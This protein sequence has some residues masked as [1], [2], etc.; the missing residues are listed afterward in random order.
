MSADSYIIRLAEPDDVRHLPSVER[1]AGELFRT[2]M[3]ETGL[4]P[5]KLDDVSDF[6]ELEDARRRNHLW[7]ATTADGLPIAWAMALILDGLA[8][9]DEIDVLPEHGRQGVGTRLLETV[10]QWAR[11]A[12][13][14]KIT[15]STFRD[16]PWNR[17]FYEQ[18]GFRVVDH[19]ALLPEHRALVAGEAERGLRTDLRVMMERDLTRAP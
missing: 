5:E 18:R 7:V 19:N 3:E 12:G 15:L 16:V 1:R 11:D 13:Y 10:C 4:T 14:R 2:Y 6:D 8:H 17:P 9:L